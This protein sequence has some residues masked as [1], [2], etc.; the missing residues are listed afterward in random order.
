MNFTGE[1]RNGG[2]FLMFKCT[3]NSRN[4]EQLSQVVMSS[5][6]LLKERVGNSRTYIRTLQRDLDMSIVFDLPE[7]V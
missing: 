2:G 1:L 3:P 5:P 7:G 6:K 4:L